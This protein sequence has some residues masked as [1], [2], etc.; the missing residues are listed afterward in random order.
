[1]SSKL[2][3]TGLTFIVAVPPV[4]AL[5]HFGAAA[6]VFIVIGAVVMVIGCVLMLLDR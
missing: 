1:M 2:L 5:F 3:W 6:A 4:L